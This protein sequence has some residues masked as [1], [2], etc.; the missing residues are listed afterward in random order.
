MRNSRACAPHPEGTLV[1]LRPPGAAASPPL[2]TRAQAGT[3]ILMTQNDYTLGLFNGDTAVA[4]MTQP[5]QSSVPDLRCKSRPRSDLG[6]VQDRRDVDVDRLLRAAKFCRD[7]L[8]G[9]A[10]NQQSENL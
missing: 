7:G 8:V 1:L 9:E 2:G 4:V 6:L 5:A 10:P 3:P